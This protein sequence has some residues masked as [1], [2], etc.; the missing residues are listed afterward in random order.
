MTLP[1]PIFVMLLVTKVLEELDIPYLIG[2]SLASTAYGMVRTTQ[3]V[4]II[5]DLNYT[6]IQPIYRALTRDFYIDDQMI[7]N[8]IQQNSSFNIIHRGTMFKVDIFIP[9]GTAF[10]HSQQIRA[11]KLILGPEPGQSANFASPED[12]I[13]SK[14]RWFRIGGEVSERQW[15]DT[16]GILKVGKDNL[17]F[18]YLR[19]WAVE[20]NVFDLL[21]KALQEAV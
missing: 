14:L 12:T 6:H 13:L 18:A 4:D 17:D 2:G 20:L 3:D 8:A 16:I 1:E 21:N 19:D 10:E 9:K 7:Q 15:R 11:R 5:A